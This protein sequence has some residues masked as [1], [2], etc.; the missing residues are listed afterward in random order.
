[1]TNVSFVSFS[2]YVC[3]Y[4]QYLEVRK[5][6]HMGDLFGVI[7][8]EVKKI[9]QMTTA[10][11]QNALHILMADNS[12]HI[13]EQET[14]ALLSTIYPPPSA[15]EVI[16]CFYIGQ[17]QHKMFILQQNGQICIYS[18]AESRAVLV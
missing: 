13:Y 3:L 5:M 18:L 2:K 14:K 12:V 1:M 4:K 16:D 8:S 10:A 9:G 6:H 17:D 11:G 7:P 15:Q